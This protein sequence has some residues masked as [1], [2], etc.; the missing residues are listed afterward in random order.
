MVLRA[1]AAA[2][3][4]YLAAGLVSWR[5]VFRSYRGPLAFYDLDRNDWRYSIET[6]LVSMLDTAAVAMAPRGPPMGRPMNARVS[7]GFVDGFETVVLENQWLRAVI[8]PALGGRVWELE[9][10][11]RRR[12]WIWHRPDVRLTAAS[13]RRD[14]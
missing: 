5:D 1:D 3:P 6:L 13:C 11:L 9:D 4:N 12:Q 14:L 10:R 8:I 7:S 2:V